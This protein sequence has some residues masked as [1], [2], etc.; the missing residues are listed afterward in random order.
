LFSLET[1]KELFRH[2][3]WADRTVWTAVD[4]AS[5]ARNDAKIHGLLFHLHL[6][7]RAF[8][9]VWEGR[10]LD[11][12]KPARFLDL[13]SLRRWSD[14]YYGEAASYLGR[15]EAGALDQPLRMPWVAEFE[16]QMGQ[17]FSSPTLGETLFQ[18][19][20]HSTYHRGQVNA[21]LRELG[22]VPPLVDFIAWVWMGK[23]PAGDPV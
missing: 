22:G 4:V 19:T 18:V 2:M 12:P 15:L 3:E 5:G 23:P 13:Q 8:L 9:E 20:S 17:A 7:Q 21:R 1:L 16:R 11:L 14:A 10:P 6:V